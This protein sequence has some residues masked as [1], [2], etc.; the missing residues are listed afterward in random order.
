MPVTDHR[1]PVEPWL[2]AALSLLVPGLGQL[3][4]GR[5][6]RALA[7][8]A[9][10]LVTMAGTI[11]WVLSESHASPWEGLTGYAGMLFFQWG[12]WLDACLI[13]R[14]A[15][16]RFRRLRRPALALFLSVFFPGLGQAYLVSRR[17]LVRIIIAPVFA[18][19]ALIVLCGEMLES[20]AV[21]EIPKW[22]A[23][24]PL[25][26]AVPAWAFLSL[27][28]IT[29]AW[30]RS[31]R[32]NGHRPRLPRVAPAVGIL[33][34]VFWVNGL[35]PWE[36]MSKSRVRTFKIPSS[37]MEPTLLIGDRLWAKRIPEF[38]RG[39]IVV[40]KPPH[41]PETDY[42]KRVVG[43]PGERVMVRGKT[44]FVN[45]GKLDEPWAVWSGG[46][47]RDFGPYKVPTA[48][49]FL[50][51]DNRDQSYDSRYF[52]PVPEKQVFGR[53]YKLYWPFRRAVPLPRPAR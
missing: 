10:M 17:W 50:M 1:K 29:H 46:G 13:T 31:F 8:F 2:A 16:P 39:D 5:P 42:I 22:L 44:V 9:G 41:A 34:L 20:S 30:C 32:K 28:S 25:T 40:F 18:A 37:S 48:H 24:W 23:D 35:V 27:S 6:V 45:G 49:L 26:L 43:L 15:R 14:R 53:A 21:P 11:A 19:P 33:A 4:A 36:V 52:G 3:H 7:W 12:S 47:V 51:G 38:R